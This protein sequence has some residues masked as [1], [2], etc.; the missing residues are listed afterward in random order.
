MFDGIVQFADY[1]STPVM[2]A[3][4]TPVYHPYVPFCVA[5]YAWGQTL[6][7]LKAV[8][9]KRGDVFKLNDADLFTNVITTVEA[10]LLVFNR[11]APG[12]SADDKE[13]VQNIQ[14]LFRMI[15]VPTHQFTW[16][17]VSPL[18]VDS[19][20]LDQV[21]YRNA[22]VGGADLTGT[23]Q[24]E[25]FPARHSLRAFVEVRGVG[26]GPKAPDFMGWNGP[27]ISYNTTER[28]DVTAQ[29]SIVG[30]VSGG[31]TQSTNAPALADD[32]IGYHRDITFFTPE[33]GW[34]ATA[35]TSYTNAS[36]EPAYPMKLHQYVNRAQSTAAQVEMRVN[37]TVD[38]GFFMQAADIGAHQLAWL[39]QT[40]GIPYVGA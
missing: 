4:E 26:A 1:I 10:L 6:T 40:L 14:S 30:M 2:G 7:Q 20:R 8:S 15:G 23:D 35:A 5:H 37:D 3:P 18:V 25:V 33:D 17:E 36:N 34:L 39:S 24:T 27:M 11:T 38:Y 16:S 31:N 12:M 9:G 28:Y 29:N 22:W 32:D 21:L 13:D 19:Q